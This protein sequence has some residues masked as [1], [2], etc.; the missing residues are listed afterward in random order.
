MTWNCRGAVKKQLKSTFSRF[1]RKFGV[2]VAAILEPRVSGNKALNIIRSLGFNNSI[3][4]DAH[5]YSGGIWVVWDPVDINI[6]LINKQ[7][8]F[9]HVWVEFPGKEGFFWTAV[10]ASTHEEKRKLVWEDLKHIGRTMNEPWMLSGDFNEIRSATEKKG[11]CPADLSRCKKFSDVL[12]ACEVLELGG[13]GNRFTW[14]GPKFSHLDRV[15][16]R[17]DKVVA[18]DVWRTRFE[19]AEVLNLPRIFSDHCPILVRL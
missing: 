12:D 19:D 15:F 7:D 11:G 2:G 17:L 8:Q 18:N 1:R 13:G 9:I 6:T 10:Y 4:S 5:G 3:I 14:K 16:K